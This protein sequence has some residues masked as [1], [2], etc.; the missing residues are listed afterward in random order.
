MNYLSKQSAKDLQH[1][2]KK[3][4]SLNK[5][6]NTPS[7]SAERCR[8]FR[9]SA[10]QIPTYQVLGLKLHKPAQQAEPQYHFTEL[11]LAFQPALSLSKRLISNGY[12]IFL[13]QH[14]SSS[15]LCGY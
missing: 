7:N 8:A 5:L 15:V 14:F 2:Q 3:L 12:M 13:H 1:L 11:A 4:V 10:V 9:H 6:N